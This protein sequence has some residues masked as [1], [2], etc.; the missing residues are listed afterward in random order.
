MNTTVTRV[1]ARIREMLPAPLHAAQLIQRRERYWRKTGVI[2]IH[3]P[4]NA[5]TSICNAI[6]GRF[7]GHYTV[8]E[9]AFW[10]PGLYRTL[11]SLGLC[12]NPWARTLSAYR[13][14]CAGAAM[15]DGAGIYNP[16]R[17][18]IDAFSSFERF[19]LEWLAERDIKRLDYVFRS[20]SEFLVS[21]EGKIGVTHLG[22]L[23]DPASYHDF[24]ETT[25]QRK[26]EIEHINRTSNPHDYRKAYTPEMRDVIARIYADDVARFSYDF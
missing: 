12:R 17:Y 5:G 21:R 25:L 16:K 22:R 26:V 20:Q 11:P 18:Q 9:V 6:Y 24:L 19:I 3:V 8:R 14:A 23:E 7:I 10:R 13:F 1:R 2:F 15:S 4:K